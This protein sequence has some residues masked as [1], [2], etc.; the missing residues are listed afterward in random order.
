M[1]RNNLNYDK[2]DPGVRDLVYLLNESVPFTTTGPMEYGESC[3]GHLRK[4]IDLMY[5]VADPGY[6]FIVGGILRFSVDYNHPKA[7]AFLKEVY[8][9][10]EKYEFVQAGESDFD[11]PGC[12]LKGWQCVSFNE[13]DLWGNER[14]KQ[15]AP[16]KEVYKKDFQIPAKIARQRLKEFRQVWADFVEIAKRYSSQPITFL[17]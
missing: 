14:L 7:K 1:P 12:T 9:L 4:K 13:E 15:S 6:Y 10:M 2:I 5:L 16:T 3:E 11:Y 8:G 17:S